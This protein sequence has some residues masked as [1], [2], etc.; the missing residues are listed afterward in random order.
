MYTQDTPDCPLI[1]THVHQKSIGYICWLN[2]VTLIFI[3]SFALRNIVMDEP[4]FRATSLGSDRNP[5]PLSSLLFLLSA[6]Q[7]NLSNLL[8]LQNLMKRDPQSYVE[9]FTTQ[10]RHYQSQLHMF[11]L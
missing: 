11:Q 6:M 10:Y 5:A 8:N 1:S 7:K 3:N 9:E 2:S 4:L